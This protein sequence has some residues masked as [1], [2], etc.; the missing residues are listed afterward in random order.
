MRTAAEFV[1]EFGRFW[2]APS[3]DGFAILLRPDVTLVQPLAPTMHGL[4]EVRRGFRSVFVWLPDL[5]GEV[6]R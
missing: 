6:D 4:D 2:S 5:R 1:E 3:L